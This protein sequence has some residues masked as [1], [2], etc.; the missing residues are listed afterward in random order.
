MRRM[1]LDRLLTRA[2]VTRRE[3]A[4]LVRRGCVLCNGRPVSDPACLLDLDEDRVTLNGQSVRTDAQFYVMLH[5]P[6]GVVTATE[7][8]RFG[9]VMDCLPKALRGWDLLPV[10]RLDRDTTGLL[11]L[12]DD[13][14][15]G[16][17]LISPR[18]EQ[19]KVYVALVTGRVTE[20]DAARMDEGI[21]LSDFTCR[22]ARLTVLEAGDSQSLCE[23]TVTEGKYHQ[24]KRMFGALGHEVLTL[25]RRRVAGI[26]LDPALEPGQWRELTREEISHLYAVTEMEAPDHG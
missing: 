13:G 20:R 19:E 21:P 7:D 26:D 3:A 25:H 16:H 11:F 5:K 4:A 10:G 24:V 12:T 6:A 18:W 15:L 22:P 2:G 8:G 1:R 14:Q 23:V 17:R 9:T